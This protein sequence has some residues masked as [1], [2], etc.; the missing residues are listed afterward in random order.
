MALSRH[1]VVNLLW[2]FHRQAGWQSR[3][4][5]MNRQDHTAGQGQSHDLGLAPYAC[6]MLLIESFLSEPNNESPVTTQ[7]PWG[8]IPTPV[9][10]QLWLIRAGLLAFF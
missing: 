2:S 10:N 5:E 7:G 4:G 6:L 1:A 3:R 9:V 8:Q